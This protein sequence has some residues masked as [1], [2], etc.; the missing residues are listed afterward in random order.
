[1]VDVNSMPEWKLRFVRTY[2][3]VGPVPSKGKKNA[4]EVRNPPCLGWSSAVIIGSPEDKQLTIFCPHTLQSFRVTAHAGEIAMAVDTDIEHTKLGDIIRK[5]WDD[6]MRM[7]LPADTG[8]ASLVLARMGQ[9]VPTVSTRTE[10]ARRAAAAD[11]NRQQAPRREAET[12][13]DTEAR[14]GRRKNTEPGTLVPVKRKV[15]LGK[16]LQWVLDHPGQ[17]TKAMV[18]DINILPHS[19]RAALSQLNTKHGIGFQYDG[20][21]VTA[22]LPK[23]C[24]DPFAKEAA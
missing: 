5:R 13:T 23:G 17:S 21:G 2:W 1:M 7:E 8:V 4:P 19:A 15:Q 9:A 14:S 3:T 20:D 11:P 22:L 12:E 6:A 18:T 10:Y 16:V 24:K